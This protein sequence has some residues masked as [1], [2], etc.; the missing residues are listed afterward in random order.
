MKT[1]RHLTST[2]LMATGLLFLAA[3]GDSN[4][5]VTLKLTD[6]P[7]DGIEKAVVTISKV[8]LKGSVDKDEG[9]KGDVVL[10][11]EP[12]TTDL[13][14]L[15]NDTADL[16]K[17]A[18]VP[19]GTY[20]ELRFV[21]TGGYIQVKQDGVS[22]IFATSAN[23][24][25]LPEG[26]QVDGDL[27][28]PS[29]SSSGLKV[30]FD[31]DADVTITSDDDQKVILVDFDVAQSFGKEA[32]NSGKW[33][34]RP[35]IKGADLEFSG[36]VEVTLEA[37]S[38]SL[39]LGITQLGSFSAVLINADGSR[40]TLAF[41]AST[42]TTYVADFKYLLPG[43]YQVDLVGPEGVSFTTDITRPATATVSSGAE[44]DVH[45]VLTSFDVE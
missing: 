2:L 41:S 7:G 27:H 18:E 14:T 20:K 34:M 37:G 23:Y 19:A 29:A 32:G 35:V 1:L 26:A 42:G 11:S 43:T 25:G 9:G 15:A 16:V 24:E 39:P 3:C 31:K 6:A 4:A 44:S 12:V 45:F 22:R 17:D 30:K 8:Y 28:M 10:L 13:L 40:E 21:I 36:N 5:R 33:V 38:V